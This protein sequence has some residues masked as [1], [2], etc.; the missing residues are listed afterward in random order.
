MV[1]RTNPQETRQMGK[2]F[3]AI[4]S[5]LIHQL[6]TSRLS[7][8]TPRIVELL[9]VDCEV[10]GMTFDA[11]SDSMIVCVQHPDWESVP[12]FSQH[13]I[14]SCG[15]SRPTMKGMI[16]AMPEKDRQDIFSRYFQDVT[17]AAAGVADDAES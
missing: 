5:S 6:L 11:H 1:G 10:C 17:L 2:R 8:L 7:C 3:Y 4:H 12:E 9:P 14:R 13:E 15:F 16:D